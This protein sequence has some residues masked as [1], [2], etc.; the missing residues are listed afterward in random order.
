MGVA[1]NAA[2][3]A[4]PAGVGTAMAKD[5]L[6]RE[7]KLLGALLGQVIIEQEG[8]HAFDLVE[9]VRRAA[10]GRRR[11]DDASSSG[12]LAAELES[13]D[14]RQAA[15][16]IRAFSL[17]FQLTNLAEEKHR[18]RKLRERARRRP[19]GRIDESVAAAV[20][21]MRADGVPDEAIE[22]LT[23][24]LVIAPVL[25]A[26]PTEARR[27]TMLMALRRAYRLLD[28]LDDPRLTPAEDEDVR[29]GLREEISVL[30]HMAP[31]RSAAPSP[32]DEVRSAMALF[33]QTLFV[34]VPQLYRA[35]R[36]SLSS[37]DGPRP[38]VRWGSWIGGDRDGNPR[39]TAEVT[40]T[41]MEIQ[42]DHVLRAY[43]QVCRRLAQ[44]ITVADDATPP[45]AKRLI[46]DARDFPDIAADLDARFPGEPFR[47]RFAYMAERLRRTREGRPSGYDHSAS[48]AGEL[49]EI[50]VALRDVGLDRVADGEL[51]NLRWQLDTFK[52]HAL[53]LEVRQHSGVHQELL[54]D[55][56]SD[57]DVLE[58]IRAIRDIQARFGVEACHRYVVSFTR[59]ASDVLAVLDLAKRATRETPPEL[60]VVPLFE[61][62][63]ALASSAA[64]IDELL[65]DPAYASHLATRGQRQEVMLGYSDSTKESGPMASAWMLYRAQ[66][67]LVDVCRRHGVELTLFHGRGGAI[68]RGGGPMT[69]AVLAQAPGSVD[70]RL[71]ITEQGEVMADRYSNPQIAE[72]HLEQMTYAALIATTTVAAELD[73]VRADVMDELARSA[74]AAYRQL[75]WDSP[76]FE[77]FFSEATPIAE[78]AGLAIG[79]RPAARSS[80]AGPPA[81]EAL[82]AIPWVFAWSQSRINLPGW[83]GTGTALAEY[84]SRRGKTGVRDLRRLYAEWPFFASVIDV[85]EMTLAKAEM[86][87]GARYASLASGPDGESI[88]RDIEAEFRRTVKAILDITQRRRLLDNMPVL[89]RSIRLRNP[90]VDSLSELQV[91]LLKHARGLPPDDPQLDQLRTLIH[92]TVSGV[93]AG[94][95][96][97]G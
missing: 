71:K 19:D 76:A 70:G 85:C 65:S 69:R 9:R 24:R 3:R 10:I 43:E 35:V 58:T 91:R 11:S 17:Y 48:F 14:L 15:V 39:V 57:A 16:L 1:D 67:A 36:R 30:W 93:S 25:T 32:L 55:G 31:V 51:L 45:V 59:S 37:S 18:V 66:T 68:G 97:T 34:M 46:D 50:D 87:I 5:P 6:A 92:E 60:D 78:L 41:A 79:S 49:E 82:R 42:S 21:E 12:K 83:Y 88:W 84:L 13:I 54:T 33:D 8:T 47:R 20:A 27:R 26:H 61:S 94:L 22:Q 23:Q 95:Q 28:M 89:Q 2:A 53:S 38:F 4:E 90:Y 86:A 29:R 81:L 44:T 74:R 63:D 7:V 40:S 64:I 80:Q 73:P 56:S 62:A 75:V 96:N 72:R 52:F 77:R